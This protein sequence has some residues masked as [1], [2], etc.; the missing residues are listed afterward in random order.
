MAMTDAQR[1]QKR[2]DKMRA[3]GYEQVL[4]WCK[5]DRKHILKDFAKILNKTPSPK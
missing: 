2:R 3:A 1:Q 5:P 4:I